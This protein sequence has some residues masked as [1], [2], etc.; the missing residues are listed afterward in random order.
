MPKTIRAAWEN[1]G[2]K[3]GWIKPDGEWDDANEAKPGE[4]PAFAFVIVQGAIS[5]LPVPDQRF[6]ID[7]SGTRVTSAPA[8]DTDLREL[9]GLKQLQAL[10][11]VA[12]RVTDVGLKELAG[13][14][15]LLT[16]DLSATQVTGLKELSRLPR[17]QS[18]SLN[19]T[20]VT[21]AGLKGLAGLTELQTLCLRR[22][23]VADAG[24]H[25]LIQA[26]PRV[27][28]DL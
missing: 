28:V 13:L 3:V 22:D 7:L 23:L 11:L 9:A 14:T 2:A 12:T 10:K 26:L 5:K 21:D 16:L 8:N 15:Q 25:G 18:L 1:A 6:G 17:L 20:K 24:I 4:I 27:G 19:S